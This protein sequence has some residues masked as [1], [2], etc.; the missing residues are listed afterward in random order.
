L[1][2]NAV[3]FAASGGTNSL[4]VDLRL[5]NLNSATFSQRANG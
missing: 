1:A 5:A 2:L 4:R 3:H